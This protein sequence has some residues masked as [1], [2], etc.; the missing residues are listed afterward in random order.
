M[1]LKIYE[2]DPAKL[3]SATGWEGEAVL[4]KTAVKLE[5][6][7]DNNMLLIVLEIKGEICHTMHR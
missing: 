6:L 4:K 2:L 1:Y 7:T 3:F 5:L